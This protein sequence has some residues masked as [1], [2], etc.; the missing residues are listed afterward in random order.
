MGNWN[1][2]ALSKS[3][4]ATADDQ[5]HTK[6]ASGQI[7]FAFRF[8][9]GSVKDGIITLKVDH[10]DINILGMLLL[11]ILGQLSKQKCHKKGKEF[12]IFLTPPLSPQWA[13]FRVMLYVLF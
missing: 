9:L 12:I 1:C 10:F 2:K 5:Y 8:K 4:L 6:F 13:K 11:D 3:H 7:T